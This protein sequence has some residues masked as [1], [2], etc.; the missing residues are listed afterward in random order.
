MCVCIYEDWYEFYRIHDC[1]QI[2]MWECPWI[3]IYEILTMIN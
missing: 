3:R 1:D 2:H